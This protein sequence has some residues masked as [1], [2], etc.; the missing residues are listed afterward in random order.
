MVSGGCWDTAP[1]Y[2]ADSRGH[3][4]TNSRPGFLR[5]GCEEHSFL[6]WQE[7][8]P[9]IARKHDLTEAEET[10]YRGIVDRFFREGK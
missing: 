8:F 3:G 5:I 10:E 7:R 4:A 9:A 6:D 1:L 2:V